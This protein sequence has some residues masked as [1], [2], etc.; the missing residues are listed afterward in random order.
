MVVML[1][2]FEQQTEIM[3]CS[4]GTF[5]IMSEVDGDNFGGFGEA[6][7][8]GDDF[9]VCYDE[10]FN[11]CYGVPGWKSWSLTLGILEVLFWILA[12]RFGWKRIR[13]KDERRHNTKLDDED[14]L[15]QG[16]SG[17]SLK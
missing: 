3:I 6:I 7:I 15:H 8:K 4:S 12:L 11:A 9:T 2:C 5:P 13:G 16:Q 14:R 10:V 1:V 17:H